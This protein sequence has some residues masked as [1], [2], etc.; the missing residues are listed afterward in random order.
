MQPLPRPAYTP[1]MYL[2]LERDA[3][4]KHEFWYGDIYA[5]AGGSVRHNR[6]AAECIFLLRRA[7]GGGPCQP[8]GSDQRVHIPETGNYCYP[9][10]TVICGSVEYDSND[11]QTV[12]NPRLLVEVL[13]QS[14]ADH[15]RGGKF[16]DFQTIESLEEV[17]FV[18]QDWAR[19]EVRRRGDGGEWTLDTYQAGDTVVL[20]SVGAEIA[21]DELYAGAFEVRGEG[22]A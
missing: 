15:D 7:L 3:E 22:S 1:E 13:S 16:E 19:V 11:G 5:M 18:R 20:G 6:L 21:V 9:D 10:V 2:A 4:V 12:T 8:Y 17:V 14:T